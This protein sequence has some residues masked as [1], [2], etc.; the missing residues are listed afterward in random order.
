MAKFLFV[1]FAF[2]LNFIKSQD[3]YSCLSTQPELNSDCHAKSNSNSLCCYLVSQASSGK[4]CAW[5]KNSEF[6]NTT[7]VLNDITYSVDCGSGAGSNALTGFYNFKP[8]EQPQTPLNLPMVPCGVIRPNT[9]RDC[10]DFSEMT[11]SCCFYSSSVGTGCYYIGRKYVGRNSFN[12]M[13]V[14]C[15]SYWHRIGLILI[16]GLL[17]LM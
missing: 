17:I 5:I 8:Y 12:N 3:S 15:S 11:N 6:K 1:F 13:T 16:L 7:L 9:L 2:F 14:E 4:R 10:S